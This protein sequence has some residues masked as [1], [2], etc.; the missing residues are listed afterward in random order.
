MPSFPS[1]HQYPNPLKVLDLSAPTQQ[2]ARL[3]R[4]LQILSATNHAQCRTVSA[5]AVGLYQGLVSGLGLRPE[6]VDNFL[7]LTGCEAALQVWDGP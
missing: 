6:I 7:V 4:S 5:A 2:K 3:V 1:W